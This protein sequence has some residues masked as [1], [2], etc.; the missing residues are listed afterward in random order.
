ML[1]KISIILILGA[2]SVNAGNWSLDGVNFDMDKKE[3]TTKGF[4]CDAQTCKKEFRSEKNVLLL[5]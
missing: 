5:R 1:S 3:L 4:K 2:L